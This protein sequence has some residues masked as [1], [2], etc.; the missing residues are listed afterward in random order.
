MKINYII[1]TW[2]GYRPSAQLCLSYYEQVLKNHIDAVNRY[3]NT[4]SQITIMKPYC[5]TIN[6]YY[7]IN[8]TNNMKLIECVNEFQSYGQW[9][10]AVEKYLNDFDYFIFVEDDYVP[11]IDNFD[12]KLIEIYEEGTYLCSMADTLNNMFP[13]HAAISNG[14]ISKKLLKV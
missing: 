13:H 14:I 4:I 7:D 5:N 1:A 9:L 2:N 12:M 11:A 3:K 8:L 10:K 6:S